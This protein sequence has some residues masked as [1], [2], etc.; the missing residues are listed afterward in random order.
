L[1]V[2]RLPDCAGPESQGWAS[3]AY[4]ASA[5][6]LD[7]A[8]GLVSALS[9]AG[10]GDSLLMIVG[11]H[12]INGKGAASQSADQRRRLTLNLFGR[13]V[14]PQTLENGSILDIA[15]TILW[16]LGLSIPRHYEGRP[17][18]EAFGL[19]EPAIAMA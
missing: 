15:P 2:L 4:A 3:P 6:R 17:L 10:S 18:L 9:G 1:I 12:R 11:D 5:Q 13:G 14:Y 16:S 8:L 19:R 7:Q